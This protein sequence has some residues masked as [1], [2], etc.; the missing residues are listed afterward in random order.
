MQIFTAKSSRISHP[1]IVNNGQQFRAKPCRG[2]ISITDKFHA[3]FNRRHPTLGRVPVLVGE[4]D[5][6][7]YRDTASTKLHQ[8]G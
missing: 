6:L 1:D 8:E 7:S 3:P 5:F 2:G 4:D